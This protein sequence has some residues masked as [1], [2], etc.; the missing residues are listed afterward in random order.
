MSS[1]IQLAKKLNIN[2]LFRMLR[3]ENILEEI[4]ITKNKR[5]INKYHN[6]ECFLSIIN[7]V[8]FIKIQCPEENIKHYKNAVLQQ[9]KEE[10]DSILN[11]PLY[12]LK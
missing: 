3:R 12:I 1:P 5:T 11:K 7:L 4:K 8:I 10:H 9:I 6:A 2:M